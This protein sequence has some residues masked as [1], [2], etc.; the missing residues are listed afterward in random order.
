M[1]ELN[2]F[3]QYNGDVQMQMHSRSMNWLAGRLDWKAIRKLK[4]FELQTFDLIGDLKTSDIVKK[5]ECELYLDVASKMTKYYLYCG[6][7]TERQWWKD[8]LQSIRQYAVVMDKTMMIFDGHGEMWIVPANVDNVV[9]LPGIRFSH[10]YLFEIDRVTKV[11][12]IRQRGGENGMSPKLYTK[13]KP[14]TYK[15]YLKEFFED[16]QSQEIIYGA[17]TNESIAQ[18]TIKTVMYMAGAF[19]VNWIIA[20]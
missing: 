15:K 12:M 9:I 19:N 5:R 3:L 10:D 16:Q 2:D 13:Y 8:V 4:K 7:T 6:F 17:Y 11:G 14:H 18:D 20:E 1:I